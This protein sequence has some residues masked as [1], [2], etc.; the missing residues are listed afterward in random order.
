MSE[1]L[2]PSVQDLT[3]LSRKACLRHA[4]QNIEVIC[5]FAK[6]WERKDDVFDMF[7]TMHIVHGQWS[8]VHEFVRDANLKRKV[9]DGRFVVRWQLDEWALTF[10]S[11]TTR[12]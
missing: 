7:G 6:S 1:E 2:T 8:F 11:R 3:P 4:G 5:P 9:E 12:Q 10:G